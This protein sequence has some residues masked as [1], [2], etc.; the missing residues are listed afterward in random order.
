MTEILL[1]VSKQENMEAK[2]KE[3]VVL[4][5]EMETEMQRSLLLE[6]EKKELQDIINSK[7][8]ITC[9]MEIIKSIVGMMR[10][11][12]QVL[13]AVNQTQSEIINKNH[14][15]NQND[16]IAELRKEVQIL[17]KAISTQNLEVAKEN[18]NAEKDEEQNDA[19]Q[20]IELKQ[21]AAKSNNIEMN[22]GIG[23]HSETERNEESIKKAANP[24]SSW[25]IPITAEHI[26]T[27][28][29]NKY[30]GDVETNY[31]MKHS[32]KWYT[33]TDNLD[34]TLVTWTSD[35]ENENSIV[36]ED[37][38]ESQDTSYILPEEEEVCSQNPIEGP[39]D[40]TPDD[41]LPRTFY[42][43]SNQENLLNVELQ[44]KKDDEDAARIH[45]PVKT[46]YKSNQIN[47][48]IRNVNHRQV[49]PGF[50]TTP[51]RM[52]PKE[53]EREE[54]SNKKNNIVIHG[55]EELS[56]HDEINELIN[57]NR[58]IGN[59]DFDKHSILRIG[60]LGRRYGDRSRPLKVELDC[61]V[62]KLNILRNAKLLEH[63]RQ[64][65]S[66]SIQHDLTRKQTEELRLMKE[67]SKE[68]ERNDQSENCR[69]RVRGPPGQW[70]IVKLPKN[71]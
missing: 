19:H 61:H 6:A 39:H 38:K 44:M 14:I 48:G 50:N 12:F 29:S 46:V 56:E 4:K 69:Y 3:I 35:V 10:E 9:Y 27:P 34:D 30:N 15:L 17:K 23:K 13:E 47:V 70:K 64:Y 20:I 65:G 49:N 7:A 41:Y 1:N 16:E 25:W 57:I 24:P 52:R 40:E 21:D 67:E 32:V 37:Q 42:Y 68:Q 54:I 55:L 43:S 33:D 8:E 28:D 63:N 60:R 2:N 18:G 59:F 66:I 11:K 51:Q 36:L 22:E 5:S 45:K 31:F 53:R 71:Y 26:N 58:I 62:T